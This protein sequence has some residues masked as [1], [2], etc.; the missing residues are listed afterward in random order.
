MYSILLLQSAEVD[1]VHILHKYCH[2]LT[3]YLKVLAICLKPGVYIRVFAHEVH[4]VKVYLDVL[5]IDAGKG[6]Q[7]QVQN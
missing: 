7:T 1:P 2:L 4:L 3:A 5:G 6:Y